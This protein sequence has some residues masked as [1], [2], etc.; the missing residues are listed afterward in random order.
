MQ[1][2]PNQVK[3]AKGGCQSDSNSK[4]RSE[5]SQADLKEVDGVFETKIQHSSHTNPKFGKIPFYIFQKLAFGKVNLN[6]LF[7]IAGREAIY[8]IVNLFT[9]HISLN[10]LIV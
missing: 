7:P 1:M 9:E 10:L 8:T 4:V 6:L 3:K 2:A 5:P